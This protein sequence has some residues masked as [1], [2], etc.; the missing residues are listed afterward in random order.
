MQSFERKATLPLILL[1]LTQCTHNPSSPSSPEAAPAGEARVVI[2]H[3][4]DLHGQLRQSPTSAAGG[5]ARIAQII[6]KERAKASSS[7]DVLVLMGGDA[8]G[9]G[10]LPCRK[11]ED[12]ACA[13]LLK[14]LGVD[15][16]VLGNGELKRSVEDLRKLME[17]SGIP[18]WVSPNIRSTRG[19][20]P[21]R[22]DYR[23]KGPKSGAEFVVAS[24]TTPPT[25]G[26]ID[27]KRAGYDFKMKPQKGDL[28]E[29]DKLYPRIPVLWVTHQELE[30]DL[31][32]SR[33]LCENKEIHKGL[34][35]LRAHT[36]QIRKDEST[37]LPIYEAGAFGEAIN[38]LEL[39]KK[40]GVWKILRYD[41]IAVS[42]DLAEDSEVKAK[43][44]AVYAKQ[45]PEA[46]ETLATVSAPLSQEQLSQWLADAYRK[47]SKADVAII[48]GGA[49]KMGAEAG[50]L[51]LEKLTIAIPYNNEV[52]GLDWSTKEL[53]RS[54]CAASM[55]ERNDYEDLGS[56][57]FISGAKLVN[58]GLPNC[59]LEGARAGSV[60][61]VV[62]NYIVSR[63]QR[64][65]GKNLGA[66][67]FK[68]GMSTEQVM[69]L[70]L[71]KE[72][73]SP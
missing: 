48:N 14:D 70:V 47:A 33:H 6:K 36:H 30:A 21:W 17:G 9:K 2:L 1:L 58:A 45:A 64:W 19:P 41:L 24:W 39:V 16:A 37:C 61:V 71:K 73:M 25:P 4:S 26:E 57:L 3:F 69:R 60:K 49:V 72:G 8:F 50:P 10:A 43:V 65:L 51:S 53:E 27:F 31:Q 67:A 28:F 29:Y 35:L 42:A 22:K 54:L 34:A 56:G 18:V 7:T 15:V 11:S 62:D 52:M 12:R 32:L 68:F 5:Y 40:A 63:S 20:S 55:R 66:T 38:R 59:V 13:P 44:E 46:D 23:W